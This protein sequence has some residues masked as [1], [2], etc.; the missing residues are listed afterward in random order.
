MGGVP[1]AAGALA[2]VAANEVAI[3]ATATRATNDF[4]MSWAPEDAP[5]GA[6]GLR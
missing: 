6:Q 5:L 4:L 1:E 3:A 2:G